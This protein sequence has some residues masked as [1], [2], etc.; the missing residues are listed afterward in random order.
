M[1]D[2][3][4]DK[5]HKTTRLLTELN[6]QYRHLLRAADYNLNRVIVNSASILSEC[7]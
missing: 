6:P 5:C 7:G 4:L 3:R 1:T 2:C